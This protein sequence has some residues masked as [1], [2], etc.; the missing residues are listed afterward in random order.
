VEDFGDGEEGGEG[1]EIPWVEE[2]IE[3]VQPCT[4]NGQR[5]HGGHECYGGPIR[6]VIVAVE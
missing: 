2:L 5:E 4:G 6:D 1:G 3:Y